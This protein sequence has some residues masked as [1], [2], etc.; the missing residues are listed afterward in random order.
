[1]NRVFQIYGCTHRG[2]IRAIN[3]DHILMG[4]FI[5][6][7][8]ALEMQISYEDDYMRDYGMLFAV[9]DGIG[10]EKAGE[11][12]SKMA[13]NAFERQ[14]YGVEKK[15]LAEDAWSAL[16]MSAGKR[17][18]DTILSLSRQNSEWAGMGSTLSG[19][20]LLPGGYL[21]YNAGDSRVCRIRNGVLKPLTNDDTV[22]GLAIEMGEMSFAEAEQSD[23]RHTITNSLGS[24]SFNLNVK[25]G[26]E[27]RGGDT[28]LIC[29]DGLHDMVDN[30]RLEALLK[31]G[32]SAGE[33]AVSLLHEAIA[34][35]GKDNISI[36]V[37][38]LEPAK[39]GSTWDR[40]NHLPFLEKKIDV[41]KNVKKHEKKNEKKDEEKDEEKRD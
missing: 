30:D 9:A 15:E 14:F 4:R 39:E 34:N 38:R 29:S 27:L 2:S 19:I 28:I 25:K 1:M 33:N 10:G 7:S 32:D 18:N 41:K 17:A 20:C 23:R 3:E 35:G 36:I 16:L 6:N 11:V 8:G 12:A 40:L 31:P 13:L 37:I 21:V 5:E 26:P 22:T 24:R